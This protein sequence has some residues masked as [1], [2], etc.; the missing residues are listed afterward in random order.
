MTGR[1]RLFLVVLSGFL[2]A[3]C[4]GGLPENGIARVN[5]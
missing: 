4:T 1:F 3:G 2:F 5:R